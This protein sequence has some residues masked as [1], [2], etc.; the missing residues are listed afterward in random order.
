MKIKISVIIVVVVLLLS[1]IFSSCKKQEE[2]I[3]LESTD[4]FKE[5]TQNETEFQ[6]YG[7]YI[8][9]HDDSLN[10]PEITDYT[11][12]TLEINGIIL[13]AKIPNNDEW[14]SG[15]YD[16]MLED[17]P[18]FI[19]E[20]IYEFLGEDLIYE[21]DS[22]EKDDFVHT[23]LTFV[24]EISQI[25]VD[26][27]KWWLEITNPNSLITS[28]FNED[29][30]NYVDFKVP[31]ND[32][33]LAITA[34][35]ADSNSPWWI[36]NIIASL[37]NDG[38]A[39]SSTLSEPEVVTLAGRL[40]YNA[41]DRHKVDTREL[42]SIYTQ[43]IFL[44]ETIEM[45][46][47][48]H[49]FYENDSSENE[50]Y[51]E[52]EPFEV[53]LVAETE[54]GNTDSFMDE[55]VYMD[56]KAEIKNVGAFD[57]LTFVCN[58]DIDLSGNS[59]I[60]Y[61][62]MRSAD[63][64]RERTRVEFDGNKILLNPPTF[65]YLPG[66]EY[67]LCVGY[68]H[69][70]ENDSIF[71][72]NIIEYKVHTNDFDYIHPNYNGN[73]VHALENEYRIISNIPKGVDELRYYDANTGKLIGSSSKSGE[74]ILYSDSSDDLTVMIL[75]IINGVEHGIESGIEIDAHREESKSVIQFLYDPYNCDTLSI[76]Y[77]IP[78]KDVYRSMLHTYNGKEIILLQGIVKD[79]KPYNLE[80]ELITANN[81]GLIQMQDR[82]PS[83]SLG[84][85]GT[86]IEIVNP[87]FPMYLDIE[88]NGTRMMTLDDADLH[89]FKHTLFTE[90][91]IL[92]SQNNAYLPIN[93]SYNADIYF[94]IP[95]VY[96]VY[97]ILAS[98]ASS[99]HNENNNVF[100]DVDN[101]GG[102]YISD[103]AMHPS[104]LDGYDFE[105]KH[106]WPNF[107]GTADYMFYENYFSDSKDKFQLF[108]DE[109]GPLNYDDMIF[110]H[111][112]VI[113][114]SD[115]L[116]DAPP[117]HPSVGLSY[118]RYPYSD[119]GYHEIHRIWG[120]TY[121]NIS[122]E[123]AF[124]TYG[125]ISDT[126][127]Y[128]R[129]MDSIDGSK[130]TPWTIYSINLYEYHFEEIVDSDLHFPLTKWQKKR[131]DGSLLW[132]DY[133]SI[134][135]STIGLVTIAMD[136]LMYATSEGQVKDLLKLWGDAATSIS[137]GHTWGQNEFFNAA[138]VYTDYDFTSFRKEY[139]H[140][141]ADINAAY[142]TAE[143]NEYAYGIYA[144]GDFSDERM[145]I[146]YYAED[147][148]TVNGK[149]LQDTYIFI[150]MNGNE[151]GKNIG[152]IIV[153]GIPQ[154]ALQYYNVDNSY[155]VYVEKGD[156]IITVQ[157]D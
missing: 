16:L 140:E 2:I 125:G 152:D 102:T 26:K 55:N 76:S 132:G 131:G 47:D 28:T 71:F 81:L 88:M 27:I 4:T 6:E 145:A 109:V 130:C 32:E 66:T 19:N 9:Q 114:K 20:F 46:V 106:V 8:F 127:Y 153:N 144:L 65:G 56:T 154:D 24:S 10:L 68:A 52:N 74:Q 147:M 38:K 108:S 64:Q 1:T 57:V 15:Y 82:D 116:L 50:Q 146:T 84:H 138:K 33:W 139:I 121:G 48:P 34:N 104:T 18:T 40:L 115:L 80:G 54:Q 72:D 155:C 51:Q 3:D 23:T 134:R 7:E 35:A 61:A 97:M 150:C 119:D 25:N 110:I 94:S 49:E 151:V 101:E 30:E 11:I 126:M 157:I 83:I 92:M 149:A 63:G 141:P 37:A 58:Q 21:Y 93:G 96:Q 129:S 45:K 70:G 13:D 143:N 73:F 44:G 156:Y 29:I 78:N 31:Q 36:E 77:Y 124:F 12:F 111:H 85:G 39:L 95:D 120:D 53:F 103:F 99:P 87:Q 118:E 59:L 14:V 98:G 69:H 41:L 128:V 122:D 133:M 137:S 100:Y 117:L 79:V 105:I 17:R 75:P 42:I 112:P 135:Y 90:K 22:F 43:I 5:S 107:L 136:M 62:Y 60:P 142:V 123:F 91:D 89:C 113:K 148:F 86:Q 67:S